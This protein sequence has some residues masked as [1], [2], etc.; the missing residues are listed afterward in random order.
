ML[1]IKIF[2]EWEVVKSLPWSKVDISVISLEHFHLFNYPE[3]VEFMNQAG[4]NV[5]RT[6]EFD[7]IFVKKNFVP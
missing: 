3:L 2:S 1:N 4:Y 7:T 5:N 6:V